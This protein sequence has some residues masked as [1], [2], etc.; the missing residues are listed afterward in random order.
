MSLEVV[1]C[2]EFDEVHIRVSKLIESGELKLDERI[3]GRGFLNVSLRQGEI[4]LRADRHVGL[5][6]LNDRIAV[7]VHPRASIANL[8]Y[9]LAHSGVAPLAIFGF[10]RGY[11]P[12]FE[13]S[14]AVKKVYARSLVEG[15][16]RILHR[17]LMKGYHRVPTPPPFRGRLLTADTIR[18]HRSRGIKY[19]HEFEYSTLSV[20]TV[21]NMALRHALSA[22]VTTSQNDKD[23]KQL[24]PEA[25]L[26]LSRLATV[27]DWVGQV[28]SL[29]SELG[30]RIPL[31]P[32]P[33]GYYR[34]PLWTAYLLLQ[35]T[36]PD[37]SADGSISLDSL[38]IDV[39]KVFE[40]YA[41]RCLFD[42]A[43]SEGWTIL[44]GNLKPSNFFVDEGK[45][46]V[47]PD[48]VIA[49][50]GKPIAVFDAK[51]KPKPKDPDRY[52]LLSFMDALNVGVGGF[53]CPSLP[54]SPSQYM[55]KTA[56]GKSMSVLRFDLSALDPVAEAD[57]LCRNVIKV[58]DG[59]R[60]FE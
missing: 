7:R 58:I 19:R 27:P 21:E 1:E 50:K 6:P 39:S 37:V 55:G 18:K 57:R 20:A 42:R 22:F 28:S 45:Y 25:R 33:L 29:I 51:Y 36:L 56:G 54:N 32:S 10:S 47:H 2:Q 3:T 53:I 48:I 31:L 13:N 30:R 41:R 49:R 23:L 60:S 17:G 59:A 15:C 16:Q 38:I 12:R 34:D 40:A 14:Q 8:S 52:E 35:Q 11:L 9:M 44:D 43:S 46:S 4:I 26:A 24:I 5:I